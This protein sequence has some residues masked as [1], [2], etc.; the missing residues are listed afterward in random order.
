MGNRPS[1][2]HKHNPSLKGL[3]KTLAVEAIHIV[4]PMSETR[5][6]QKAFPFFC[7]FSS[8]NTRFFNRAGH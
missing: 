5:W 1:N 2:N 3:H 4:W 6:D 8:Q 7:L